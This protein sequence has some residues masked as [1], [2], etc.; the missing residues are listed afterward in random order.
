MMGW[1]RLAVVCGAVSACTLSTPPD[2][3]SAPGK[4]FAAAQ[5]K[6]QGVALTK[7]KLARG[8]IIVAGPDGYCID[9]ASLATGGTR[10]FA[11]IASCRG[12]IGNDGIDSTD[13]AIVTVS[14]ATNRKG[15]TPPTPEELASAVKAPLIA[16]EIRDGVSLAHLGL[17]GDAVLAGGDQAHWRAA[18]SH[19]GYMIG[20][21]LYTP[22]HGSLSGNRGA[23]IVATVA[24]QIRA[25]SPRPSGAA[26]KAA[27]DPAPETAKPAGGGLSAF[28]QR[29]KG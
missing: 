29:L 7:A 6:T 8:K 4:G 17:Y 27:A 24:N 10:S 19:N 18:M 12:I 11:L 3:A 20:I 1:L 23:T 15:E 14:I 5:S 25:M 9:K 16:G 26:P 28:F 21:A 2:D 13:P 22:E